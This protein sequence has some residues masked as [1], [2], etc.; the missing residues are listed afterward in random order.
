MLDSAA[1]MNTLTDSNQV[2]K[3]LYDDQQ[4]LNL[5]RHFLPSQ[6]PLKDFIHHNPLHGF[7]EFKFDQALA[8]A[9]K[10]FGYQVHLSLEEYRSLYHSGRINRAALE[11]AAAEHTPEKDFTYW[12]HRLFEKDYIAHKHCRIGELRS[13]WKR[14]Y[15]ID[16]DSQTHPALFRL[17]CAYLDQGIATWHFKIASGGFLASVREMEKN[18][19]VSF[20]HSKR[21]SEL[22]LNTHHCTSDLLA[23]LIG[24]SDLYQQYILDQ[25]FAHPGWSGMVCALEGNPDSLLEKRK[26]SL[27]ELIH[28]ELLLEIDALDNRFGQSWLPLG[29]QIVSPPGNIFEPVQQTELDQV[30]TIWQNAFEKTYYDR[31]MTMLSGNR[32]K[33][34]GS[35]EKSFQ[36]LLCLDD[37]SGS[38]RRHLEQS[39]YG[40]ETFGT[41]GFFGA[42]FMFQA[43]PNPSLSKQA[44]A[45]VKPQHLIKQVGQIQTPNRGINLHGGANSLLRG[46]FISQTLGFWATFKL[47]LNI[48]RPSADL[49]ATAPVREHDNAP[50]LSIEHMVCYQPEN[51]LQIGY[52]VNEMAECVENLLRSID[53]T[54]GFAP[55]IY[56]IG[57]GAS[58]V[59]NPHFAA[60]D[61]GACSGNPGGIN[62]RVF[63]GMAN[64]RRVRQILGQ[65]GIRI[66]DQTQFLAALHD[67]TRDDVIFYDS[68]LLSAENHQRHQSFRK[69]FVNA[70]ASNAKERAQRFAS[71][72]ANLAADMAHRAVR[73]RSVSLF[74]P[75]PE[76]NHAT[77]A[78]C[79]VGH[80]NLSRGLFWDRRLFMNSYNYAS[81]PDGKTLQDILTAATPVCAGINLEYFFARTDNQR[82]GAGSKLPHNVMGLL[83][84]SN[85]IEGDLRP[86]LP[87]Q[88]TELHDP[89]R[90]LM[91]IEH[92]PSVVFSVISRSK[93]LREWFTNEW[94]H[95]IVM[96]PLT[97]AFQKLKD[98]RFIAYHALP[99]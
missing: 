9:S 70:L 7:Q 37:R 73:S 61:C 58:S 19:I 28:I 24:R 81:D 97:G 35:V 47:F 44:P 83:G 57:H 89:V 12:Q 98:D 40:C 48:F 71:V 94:V 10:I 2:G 60:Y 43:G 50:W 18:S 62:A 38:L 25:Q 69:D 11:Y 29:S 17:L 36:A 65:R 31:V 52:T 85:G 64:H 42:A 79:I 4:T 84:V 75:R 49:L 90:L 80:R 96:D 26:I 93:N 46:W 54:A 13:N 34:T 21:V 56:V 51:G 55:I 76:L 5:L 41:P 87:S 8:R 92:F 3:S 32:S 95:L 6:P 86:G 30:L 22:L 16:L 33:K 88:M 45:P 23:I 91:I 66:P 53:L 20:F 68:Q 99:L 39:D 14:L 78:V 67:T 1:F 72:D 82:L 77:N 27:S 15:Q 59:N 74:E 63:V